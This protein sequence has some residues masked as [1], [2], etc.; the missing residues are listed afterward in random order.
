MKRINRY[1]FQSVGSCPSGSCTSGSCP[2]GS[3]PS[4][5]PFIWPHMASYGLHMD[6]YGH[7]RC[8]PPPPPPPQVFSPAAAT[9]YAVGIPCQV[10]DHF[11]LQILKTFPLI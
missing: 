11:F 9:A 8:T 7:L 4:C 2:S 3:C 10:T 5:S 1:S 6:P